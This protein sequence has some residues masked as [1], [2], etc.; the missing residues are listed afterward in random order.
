MHDAESRFLVGTPVGA[1][2]VRSVGHGPPLLLWHSLFVDG[3][4]W[5]RVLPRLQLQRRLLII[6]GPGHGGSA[7]APRDYTL[8]DCAEAALRVIEAVGAAGPIDV[9]GN[10]WGGHVG[11]VL[12]ARH[13]DAVHRLVVFNSPMNALGTASR[14]RAG[15]LVRAYGRFGA[16]PFLVKAARRALLSS[17]TLA[18]DPEAA[19][20]VARTL[21]GHPHAG[22]CQAMRCVMLGRPGLLELLGSI[23]SPTVFVTGLASQHW[24]AGIAAEH[25]DRLDDG[26]CL[27][28]AKVNHL[29]PLEAPEET[30]RIIL[31]SLA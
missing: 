12:A 20:Y 13:P 10:A 28:I 1:L 14:F 30:A 21:S 3:H 7:G 25:A 24:P 22:F 2:Y 4:S 31:E 9:V 18:G 5:D 6:D 29:S 8:D 15:L 26:R 19:D 11:V 16:A 17:D 27:T 23:R